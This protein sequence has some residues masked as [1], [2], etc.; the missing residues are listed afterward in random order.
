M[1]SRQFL[2]LTGNHRWRR[3]T[4]SLCGRIAYKPNQVIK[5]CD[6]EGAKCMALIAGFVSGAIRRFEKIIILCQN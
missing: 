3:F 6:S 4:G 1:P 5:M 2:N